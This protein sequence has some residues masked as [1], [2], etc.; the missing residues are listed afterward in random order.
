[1]T[2]TNDAV[3]IYDSGV[4][5][6]ETSASLN[7]YYYGPLS[8]GSSASIL[9]VAGS[10]QGIGEFT[11]G[12]TGITAEET[13]NSS[14][15]SSDITNI[16]YDNG[17]LYLANGTV[18]NASSGALQGTFYA[19]ATNPATGPIVSDSTLGLAFIANASG[20]YNTSAVLA[21]NEATFNEAGGIDVNGVNNGTY[22][23][24]FEKIV[25]WGQDGIALN[26][27]SQIFIFESPVV[28]D[29]SSSPADLAVTL[30]APATA[31]TGTA[32]TYTAT[33][34]DNGPNQ[35]QGPTLSLTLDPSLIINSVIASQGSCGTGN[36]FNCDLGSLTNGASAMVTV[37]AT[38]TTSGT[39]EGIASVSSV[40]YD[41]NSSNDQATSNTTVTGNLYGAAPLVSAISPALV[42]AGSATFT[43]T[44]TGSGF[45]PG[46]IVNV[47]GTAETTSYVSATQLTASVDSSLV[48]N[49]GW[50]P[51][52]VSNPTPGGGTSAV[53]PLT[54]YDLVNVPANAILF[55]P[56]TQ[57]IYATVPGNSI[58]PTG[59]SVVAINPVTGS[60][61]T[62][63]NVGSQPTVMTETEDGNYL[64]I[65][66]S[67]ANSLA[68]F[69]VLNQTLVATYPL[70][71][72]QYGSTNSTVANWLSA[73]PGTDT[74][75]AIAAEENGSVGIFD[76]S[77]GTGTFRPNFSPDYGAA[78]PAFASASELYASEDSGSEF[79]RF[80]VNA[81][82]LT[83]ID[84]TNL[85]G[86][87]GGGIPFVLAGG[88][89]YGGTGGIINPSTT[90][91]SQI[92]TL[93]L[94]DYYQ[95]GI[96]PE[97]VGVV[98][99][100][101]T[102]RDFL[103]LEN[104]AGTWEYAL[105][106]YNT[107]TY[108][109][110]TWLVMPASTWNFFTGWTM[111]RWGQDGLAL[112]AVA[113]TQINSQAV[114]QILLL[115]GPFVTPQLLGTNSAASLTSSSA[116]SITHG[117]GNT[118]LTLTGSNLLPGV[119]VTWNGNY[120]TTTI[121]DGSHVTVA[122][123]ASDLASAGSGS[124]V[125]TNPG[126]PASNALTVTIN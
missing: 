126:A 103:M 24:G 74:T 50:A 95:S 7:P 69:N 97:A 114:T 79:Y 11:V 36:A 101:S 41:P 67:G 78:N 73:M 81:S 72:T 110:E 3:T 16:Q 6:A 83:A 121:V 47:G 46:S 100:P 28:K 82:G 119:A 89:V 26:T 8:F 120:R 107:T 115:Q 85:N 66:L 31:T 42:Q 94:V 77:G 43:L 87:G 88:I 123:P 49:Y 90:P 122:I 45:N 125:A 57:Q 96:S 76:I 99:D 86:L 61:G 93:P 17:Q 44:V 33:V 68:Q 12:P 118:M 18:L 10:Y 112:L 4:A 21:F 71:I 27:S 91:P 2:S 58:S 111:L 37:S 30:S 113:D 124:L 116:S 52:T 59:N 109:P 65:G 70:S 39:I 25:R 117:A 48:A 54:I 19:T 64:Y 75:L 63:I 38:P 92:A 13:I 5:R 20:V 60:V 105:A 14:S 51:V 53:V 56:Y 80:G 104:T 55:E 102:Q 108:L 22:P 84:E 29:L 1:V 62:P 34:A 40:S 23:Y 35:A 106:R 15:S 32:I 98:A 9:Y